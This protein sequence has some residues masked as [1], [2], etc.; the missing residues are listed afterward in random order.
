MD[1]YLEHLNR[2]LKTTL[3]NAGSDITD[4]SVQLA[5]Q[6]I[7]VTEHMC[8][9]IQVVTANNKLPSNKH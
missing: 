1:L 9:Q 7:A 8:Q 5:A 3:R 4:N 6:S 2:H